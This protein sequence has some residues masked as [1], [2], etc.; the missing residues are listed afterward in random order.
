MS[1][2]FS[3]R[4]NWTYNWNN[5]S[6]KAVVLLLNHFDQF[7]PFFFFFYSH[8]RFFIALRYFDHLF[9]K[10]LDLIG[11]I[12]SSHAGP[13]KTIWWGAP[14]PVY[15]SKYTKNK[16]A[17]LGMLSYLYHFFIIILKF[18]ICEMFD[19]L[20]LVCIAVLQCLLTSFLLCMSRSITSFRRVSLF[21]SRNFSTYKK[22]INL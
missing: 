22:I 16:K 14:P 7:S 10:T 9:Y 15:L 12:F 8:D 2:T 20:S 18:L 4:D 19:C 1:I 6:P 13:L 17:V 5:I 21:L 3:S 11:F